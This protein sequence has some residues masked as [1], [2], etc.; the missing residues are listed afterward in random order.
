MRYLWHK[1]FGWEYASFDFA[2]G[3]RIE[4]IKTAKDGTRYVHYC[5]YTFKEGDRNWFQIL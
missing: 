3:Q 5:G 1:L 2:F 4:R